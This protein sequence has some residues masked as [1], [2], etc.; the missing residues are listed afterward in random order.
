M[1]G[2]GAV[3]AS[4]IYVENSGSGT[5]TFLDRSVTGT[6]RT[7]TGTVRTGTGTFFNDVKKKKKKECKHTGTYHISAPVRVPTVLD[8]FY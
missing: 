6:V 5:I 4:K 2:P 8:R 7:G 3:D 1:G